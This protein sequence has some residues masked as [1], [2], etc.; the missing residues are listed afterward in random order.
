MVSVSDIFNPKLT[1]AT[2]TMYLDPNWIPAKHLLYI[3]SKVATAVKRGGARLIVSLPPRHGKSRLLSIGSTTWTVE[4]FDKY[5][6]GLCTYAA[7]LSTDFSGAVRDQI[8]LNPDKL[9]VRIRQGSNR[10]DRFLT[11]A[12]G[13]VYAFGLGGSLTGRGF[14]V[15]FLDDYIKE[16]KEAL[17]PTYREDCWTWFTTTMMTRL[18]PGASVIIVATRWHEDDLIGRAIKHAPGDW[19]YIRIPAIAERNDVLGRS[20]GEALFPERYPIEELLKIKRLLGTHY[21]SAI[22]QQDP[23]S[24]ASKMARKE[25][26][27]YLSA[28]QMPNPNTLTWGRFWDLASLQGTGDYTVGSL[29]GGHKQQQ[30][31]YIKNIVREQL[32]PE[33]VEKLV[34]ATAEADGPN[35]PIYIEEEPGASG[36]HTVY[37]FKKLLRGYV[38][39]P[40]PAIKNKAVRNASMVAGAERGDLVL[41]YGEW[42]E[43]FADEFDAIPT[44]AYDDQ[45]DT[46]SAAWNTLIGVISLGATWGRTEPNPAAGVTVT[47]GQV[48]PVTGATWG[49]RKSG[50]ITPR[51]YANG[52]SGK[53]TLN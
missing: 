5:N 32:S 44:G 31:L 47:D 42:N 40:V 36:K 34:V 30:R 23:R 11:E 46:I 9:D 21:F 17:S 38:V 19:E 4:N 29:C 45:T 43:E 14:H 49:R 12:G 27:Q 48:G 10:V 26:L 6:V 33:G 51:R 13:G 2:L 24:D 35:V 22:Y 39:R 1:P 50:L 16:I 53:V 37:Q 7:T 41:Q 18:E 15:F 28:S 52:R 8:T 25:W 3:S 20:P